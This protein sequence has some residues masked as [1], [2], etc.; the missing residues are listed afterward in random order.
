[1]MIMVADD[2]RGGCARAGSDYDAV[3]T[4]ARGEPAVFIL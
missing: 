4:C 3:R 2:D 1:M